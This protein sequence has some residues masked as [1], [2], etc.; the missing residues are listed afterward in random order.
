MNI[1]RPLCLVC[2]VFLCVVYLFMKGKPP[3]PSWD[4][5]ALN[6][7][8]L[9]VSGKI[10]DRQIKN[11]VLNIYLK[12]VHIE[13]N[14]F[15]TGA[16]KADFP[17]KVNGIVVKIPDYENI[18]DFVRLGARIE[19][20]GVFA[21]FD[22]PMNEGQFDARSYYMI[23]GYEG[24]IKRAH[25]TGVSKGYSRFAE[26]L[27]EIRDMAESVIDENMSA[28]DAGLLA[29]ITLGD[30]TGLDT[31]IK[32]LYQ[33]AGISHVLALSGLH[34]ASVGLCLLK[35]LRKIGVRLGIAAALSGGLI[36]V[37]GI[38]TGLSTSTLRAMIMFGLAVIAMIIGRTYDL[39]SAAALSAILIVAENP[40]Y[41]FDSGFLLSFGAVVA[42]GVVFS[43][44][45]RG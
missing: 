33:N 43:G 35:I 18:V 3:S 7:R 6:G 37:Y 30:K 42:I 31:E 26:K 16:D 40:G 28:E 24:Q 38:M 19:A 20:R 45:R 8:T 44:H 22:K 29:A 36:V 34:I 12:N 39:L 9:S 10:T 13:R 27:R 11:G 1:R 15:L 21:P 23:R 4:V 5:D 2:I 14:A 41:L 32:E 25:I 17:Q